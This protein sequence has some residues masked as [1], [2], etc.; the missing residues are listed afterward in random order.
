[1]NAGEPKRLLPEDVAFFH[2]SALQE[3]E[4][5]PVIPGPVRAL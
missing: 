3:I 5:I 2:Q 4:S 1:M